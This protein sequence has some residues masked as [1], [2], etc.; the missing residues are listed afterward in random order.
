MFEEIS[1]LI[2][3]KETPGNLERAIELLLVLKKKHPENDVVR[4]K[5]SHALFYKGY[6]APKHS[7]ERVKSF[8]Q[9]VHYGKEA[10]S[11]NPRAIYGNYWYGSNLGLLGM[12]KGVMASLKS[13]DPMRKA[14]EIVLE[15]DETF[16][17]AGPHRAIGRLYHQAPGWP[18]SIG[19]KSKA[20]EHLERAAEIAPKFLH[21]Q[22]YLA[23][24]YLDIG[25][26]KQAR[27]R[28][29]L[30]LKARIDP[31]HQRED[32][33]YQEEARRLKLRVL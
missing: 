7:T 29:E 32:G 19:N 5:L 3:K 8:E 31:D 27:E 21:N 23:E 14:M 11:L 2:D 9:G 12:C 24:F 1:K 15:E 20:A 17:F 18:I 13:I 26:K 22:I 25:K 4:G 6:L 10:I 16:F 28:I 30:V 33:E